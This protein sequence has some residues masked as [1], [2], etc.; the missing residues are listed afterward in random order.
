MLVV[1]PVA[2]KDRAV[3]AAAAE[4]RRLLRR[5]ASGVDALRSAITDV[6]D[7]LC[8][9]QASEDRG[10]RSPDESRRIGALRLESE[11]QQLRLQE[12]QAE[13]ERLL[14]GGDR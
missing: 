5:L 6:R 11:A 4:H 1:A 9:L 10:R 2:G 13:Y 8:A 12:Y 14:S 7:E 3:A